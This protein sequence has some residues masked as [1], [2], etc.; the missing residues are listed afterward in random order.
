MWCSTFNQTAR[1]GCLQERKKDYKKFKQH[2]IVNTHS[3]TVAFS[4]IRIGFCG[5]NF[6]LTRVWDEKEY[7]RKG[8]YVGFILA[9]TMVGYKEIRWVW[10]ETHT[11]TETMQWVFDIVCD[12][13]IVVRCCTTRTHQRTPHECFPL[14]INLWANSWLLSS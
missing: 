4:F 14:W 10:L 1:V 2:I 3:H 8:I 12:G 5:Y 7:D 13:Q 11:M 6:V 9:D